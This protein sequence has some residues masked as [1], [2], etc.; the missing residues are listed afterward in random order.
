MSCAWGGVFRAP[1]P[2]VDPQ[3]FR[4]LA[5]RIIAMATK[6]RD[7]GPADLVFIVR[8]ELLETE[9]RSGMT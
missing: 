8:E 7:C 4:F 3:W 6:A 1:D 5:Q 2:G 9:R